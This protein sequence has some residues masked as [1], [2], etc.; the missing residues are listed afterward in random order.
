[1]VRV[2]LTADKVGPLAGGFLGALPSCGFSAAASNLYGAGLLTTGTLIAVYLS[3]SDEMLAVLVG[4]KASPKLIAA[5]LAVKII[6]GVLCGFL[7][8]WSVRLFYKLREKR[9]LKRTVSEEAEAEAL[10]NAMECGCADPYCG[11]KGNVLF[12]ALIRTLRILVF[13]F[14]ISAVL[15]VLLCYVDKDAVGAFVGKMPFAGCVLT[16]LMGLIPNCAVSVALTEL[17]IEGIITA[18]MMLCGLMTGAGSGLIILFGS[19]RNK[20]ENF[21][22][23]ALLFVFALIFGSIFGNLIPLF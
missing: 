4:S 15:N 9:A 2:I 8:D 19:N 21:T 5:I 18:P 13:I 11:A 16:A 1:M 20:A 14:I 12:S 10:E 17:Y 22:V 23:V 7:C 3:T 6:T